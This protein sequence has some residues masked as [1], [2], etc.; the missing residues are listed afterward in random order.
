MTGEIAQHDPTLGSFARLGTGPGTLTGCTTAV[1]LE[2]FYAAFWIS[3]LFGT[4]DDSLPSEFDQ[5]ASMYFE[6]FPSRVAQQS[7]PA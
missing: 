3:A 7:S 4:I 1:H 2:A 6:R 5:L